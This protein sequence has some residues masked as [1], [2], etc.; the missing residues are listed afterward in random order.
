ME[1][2]KIKIG[3]THGDINGV[4]YEVIMKSLLDGHLLDI[5]TPV[6]YGSPKVAAYHRKALNIENFNFNIIKNAD[7]ANEKRP[8]IINCVDEE[9]RVE[10]G[11]STVIAGE[12]AFS[13]LSAAVK[14]LKAGKIHAIV[15]APINKYNIQSEKFKFTGHTDFLQSEFGP[16]E[17]LMLMVSD[18]LKV[19]LVSD[20]VPI[21]R[22]PEYIKKDRVLTKL[23]I[24]NKALIRDFTIRQPKIAVLGFNPHAGD[25]GLLGNEEQEEI[26]PAIEMAA[27]ENILAF[28]PYPADGFF[29]SGSFTKFDGILAMYHDQG[30]IPFKTLVIDEGVNFTAGLPV[31]RTSPAHGTA[32]EISGLNQ[33]GFGSFTKAIYL[34]RDIYFNRKRNGELLRNKLPYGLPDEL[35]SVKE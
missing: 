13:A 11:K 20:H 35:Q 18:L 31:I 3:I 16:D 2:S 22:L 10:L 34:A 8:N 17:A 1:E 27:K 6:V 33:A 23:R 21:K 14:D 12:A 15:T 24:L 19:G 30:L 5:C 9:V 28:G 29:G 26:I 4:G 32:Y 7:E 25:N